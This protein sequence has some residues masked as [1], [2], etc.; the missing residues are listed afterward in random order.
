MNYDSLSISSFSS[1]SMYVDVLA[2][3]FLCI[4]IA[5]YIHNM[6]M[7]AIINQEKL[8]SKL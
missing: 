1:V 3:L 6:N 5:Q 2:S 7:Y 8:T 4:Y